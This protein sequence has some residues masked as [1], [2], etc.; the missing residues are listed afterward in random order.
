MIPFLKL[1]LNK[2]QQEAAET[3]DGPLLILA[4]AGTGKTRVLIAR[5]STYPCHRPGLSSS[6]IGS[7]FTNKAAQEMKSRVAAIAGGPLK[8]GG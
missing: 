3:T 8:G 5:I 7:D 1:D 2:K 6:A 4:G